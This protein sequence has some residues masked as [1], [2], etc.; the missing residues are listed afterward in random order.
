MAGNVAVIFYILVI[1][2]ST[3]K[4]YG[5][6]INNNGESTSFYEDIMKR[7]LEKAYASTNHGIL[8][9]KSTYSFALYN[10][11]SNV[12]YPWVA[13]RSYIENIVREAIEYWLDELDKPLVLA[14]SYYNADFKVSFV[15]DEH[16]DGYPFIDNG[17]DR[18]IAHSFFP[19]HYKHGE[20]HLRDALTWDLAMKQD[21]SLYDYAINLFDTVL[22]E[23]G[24]VLGLSHSTDIDSVMYPWYRGNQDNRGSMNE[25]TQE[26][27]FKIY[28]RRAD[29]PE[30]IPLALPNREGGT[31]NWLSKTDLIMA[32][33]KQVYL[34]RYYHNVNA[35]SLINEH[36][37]H[38]FFFPGHYFR[39][40]NVIRGIVSCAHAPY[41]IVFYDK[42]I[43]I[44]HSG[45]YLI[46]KSFDYAMIGLPEF[47]SEVSQIVSNIDNG[48]I[49]IV[50]THRNMYTIM[51]PEKILCN[52]VQ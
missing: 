9:D 18:I 41:Y 15:D 36:F 8:E 25:I 13:E 49:G 42:K 6:T 14:K 32:T 34:F 4:I 38:N 11:P 35:I 22:H 10:L 50:D 28:E 45:N 46:V 2:A 20:I 43:I 7:T 30:V 29:I 1:C 33:K 23:F 40:E 48:P 39:T 24:H 16:G 5:E 52:P 27:L 26:E 17:E 51:D 12:A 47:I 44:H 19:N 21:K 3:T 31:F 37:E